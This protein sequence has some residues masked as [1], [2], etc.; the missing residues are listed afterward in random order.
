VSEAR[1]HLALGETGRAQALAD[2][3]ALTDVDN[4]P[5]Q[6][7]ADAAR[8]AAMLGGILPGGDR[9]PSTSA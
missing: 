1:R 5:D 6:P 9:R 7:G 4:W 3:A 2:Q 8:T